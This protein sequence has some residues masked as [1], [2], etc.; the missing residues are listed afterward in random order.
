[1]LIFKPRID[2]RYAKDSVVSHSKQEITALCIDDASEIIEHALDADVIGVDE[3]QFFGEPLV[4]V[5][6]RLANATKR[7]I[8]AGLDQDYLG[9]TLLN[10]CQP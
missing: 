3:A 8:V 9:S 10:P 6:E 7:V 5:V 1:M 4:A 2:A